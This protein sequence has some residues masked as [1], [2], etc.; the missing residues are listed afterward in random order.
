MKFHIL[1]PYV[2]WLTLLGMHNGPAEEKYRNVENGN[3][4]RSE[5]KSVSGNPG[6]RGPNLRQQSKYVNIHI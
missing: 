1:P 2:S 4:H 5:I 6:D 3:L